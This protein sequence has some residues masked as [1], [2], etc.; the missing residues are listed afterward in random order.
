MAMIVELSVLPV[1]IDPNVRK[2]RF[3]ASFN[4]EAISSIREIGAVTR[5]HTKI[6]FK[7]DLYEHHALETDLPYEEVLK[8]VGWA[9]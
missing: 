9:K 7:G 3:R 1:G 8:L 2:E 5:T 4:C 6:V